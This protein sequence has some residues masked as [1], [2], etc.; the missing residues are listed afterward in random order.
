MGIRL[1]IVLIFA[2]ASIAVVTTMVKL[3]DSPSANKVFKKELEF[4]HT[5]FIE[6]DVNKTQAK[7]FSKYG[8]RDNGILTLEHLNYHTANIQELLADKGI[9]KN[10][11]VYLLGNVRVDQ[12]EGF[13][14]TTASAKYNQK[15]EVLYIT[16]PFVAKMNKNIIRG[17]TLQYNAFKKEAIGTQIDAIVYTT[18]K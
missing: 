6:V 17:T 2:I 8:V 3:T 1:E 11:I 7:A 5:T 10:D 9:Y 13:D 18:E 12:K 15:T 14:Y 4:T 16:S